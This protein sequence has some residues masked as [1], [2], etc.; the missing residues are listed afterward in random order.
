MQQ[1]GELI[2]FCKRINP[3]DIGMVDYCYGE[4]VETAEPSDLGAVMIVGSLMKNPGGGLAP[5]GGYIC[6]RQDLVDRCAFQ[7]C[8]RDSCVFSAV[9]SNLGLDRIVAIAAPCLL[10]TSRCV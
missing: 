3:N 4:F 6:G 9:V 2:T 7:M 5:I 10:Y 8:I 1:I